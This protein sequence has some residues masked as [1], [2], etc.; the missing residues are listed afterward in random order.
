MKSKKELRKRNHY[1]LLPRKW[2]NT[3]SKTKGLILRANNIQRK[4]FN[5]MEW[6]PNAVKISNENEMDNMTLTDV[7][8]SKLLESFKVNKK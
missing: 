4:K 6:K 1:K 8:P 5:D 2:C 3:L 7:F